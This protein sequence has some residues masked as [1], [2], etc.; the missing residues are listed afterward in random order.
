MQE[1]GWQ[2]ILNQFKNYTE[3]NL[4]FF[5][6]ANKFSYFCPQSIIN[7]QLKDYYYFRD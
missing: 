3:G 6:V 1:Q 7:H 5:F 2:S 4:S